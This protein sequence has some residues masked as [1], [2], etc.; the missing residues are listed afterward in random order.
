M[1]DVTITATDRPVFRVKVTRSGLRPVFRY[2]TTPGAAAKFAAWEIVAGQHK[3]YEAGYTVDGRACECREPESGP[4]YYSAG[5]EDCPLHDHRDGYYARLAR[6]IK[7]SLLA[8]LDAGT[9]APADPQ[10]ASDPDTPVAQ[11]LAHLQAAL[12]IFAPVD[13][14]NAQEA[15]RLTNQT[16][17]QAAWLLRKESAT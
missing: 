1:S 15:A 3:V 5:W 14:P 17:T 16:I 13:D 8:S 11:A 4:G 12:S 6:E 7:A 10:P 2:F 9:P